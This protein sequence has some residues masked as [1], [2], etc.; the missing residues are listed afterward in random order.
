MK[1]LNFHKNKTD[2]VAMEDGEYPEWLWDVLK[3]KKK[4]GDDGVD[5]DLYCACHLILP[6][7]AL[8]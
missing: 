1:G 4:E 5:A 7:Q 2:P 3:P 8:N 6:S